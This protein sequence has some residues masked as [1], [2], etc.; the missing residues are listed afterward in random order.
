MSRL[1][2]IFLALALI[3]RVCGGFTVI[4]APTVT[5]LSPT[6]GPAGTAV[7]FVGTN[8]TP[9]AVVVLSPCTKCQ[10]GEVAGTTTGSAIT[11]PN[12]TSVTGTKASCTAGWSMTSMNCVIPA[13]NQG[14]YDETIC[15]ASGCVTHF[16]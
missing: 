14:T 7:T 16:E 8:Y 10:T 6:S 13:L 4:G 1:A 11:M 3:S 2:T 9:D 15:T 5:S 12:G